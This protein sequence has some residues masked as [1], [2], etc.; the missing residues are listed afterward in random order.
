MPV[1]IYHHE[2]DAA[3]SCG[4]DGSEAELLICDPSTL[5]SSNAVFE[6]EKACPKNSNLKDCDFGNCTGAMSVFSVEVTVM[7]SQILRKACE[8]I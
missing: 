7:T 8:T 3:I 1:R 5:T 6:L 4:R 2:A